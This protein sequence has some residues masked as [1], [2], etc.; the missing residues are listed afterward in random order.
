[1]AADVRFADSFT[2]FSI[3]HRITSPSSSSRSTDEKAYITHLSSRL[4]KDFHA[5]SDCCLMFRAN[6]SRRDGYTILV[7]SIWYTL[8]I[9]FVF[10]I[11]PCSMIKAALF[12]KLGP[13][14]P[15]P[16]PIQC[17]FKGDTLSVLTQHCTGGRG[18][19]TVK[20]S[21]KA[22]CTITF[23]QDCSFVIIGV[24]F[25]FSVSSPD[26][27]IFATGGTDYMVD[28]RFANVTNW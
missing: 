26:F 28:G 2:Q 13:P 4:V 12:P 3:L 19:G 21:K 1:M 24:S 16:P 14:P 23:D 17:C 8:K 5:D 22:K 6:E 20:L 7:K 9:C 27:K 25:F 11:A 18:E 10:I 15:P